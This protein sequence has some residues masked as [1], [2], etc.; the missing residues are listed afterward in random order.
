MRLRPWYAFGFYLSCLQFHGALEMLGLDQLY[1]LAWD[2]MYVPI[3]SYILQNWYKYLD[4][5]IQKSIADGCWLTSPFL[6]YINYF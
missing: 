5:I 6:Y 2:K 1:V 3:E 4:C